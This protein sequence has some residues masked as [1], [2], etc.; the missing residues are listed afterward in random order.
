MVGHNAETKRFAAWPCQSLASHY[1]A[2]KST[3]ACPSGPALPF[4]KDW[5]LAARRAK[6]CQTGI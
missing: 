6:P 2:V 4:S 5:K 1:V 3:N